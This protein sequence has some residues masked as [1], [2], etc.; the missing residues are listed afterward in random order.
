MIRS[1]WLWLACCLYL[2][3]CS[4]PPDPLQQRR[5]YAFGT[6]IDVS[7][8]GVAPEL[9]EQA[10]QGLGERFD[11][12]HEAWHAWRPGTLS[13]TN[14]ALQSG[15]PFHPEPGVAALL[16]QARD[17][18][19]RSHGLF[20]PAIGKL[21]ALWGFH[22]DLPSGPPPTD[23][24]LAPL[25]DANPQMSDIHFDGDTVSCTNPSVQVDLVGLPRVTG[26]IGLL[27]SSRHG[28]LK[29]R[30]ST[31]AAICGPSAGTA[32]DHGISAYAI[33]SAPA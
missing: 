8:Y 20:N 28:A 22:Q 4:A 7:L 6:Q 25:V 21:I 17:L 12:M 23:A 13:R 33:P 32:I 10:F 29:T 5:I 3:G 24:Q 30:S 18:S 15:Q 31:R 11:W 19:L 2:V 14:Q 26:W 1:R 9:A 16:H 27:S